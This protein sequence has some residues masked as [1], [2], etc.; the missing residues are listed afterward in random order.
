MIVKTFVLRDSAVFGRF[1]QWIGTNWEGQAAI[2]KPM[3]VQVFP[4][5]APVSPAQRG[6]YH[7]AVLKQIEAGA[8]VNGKQF[9]AKV[10]H[11]HFKAMVLG[12]NE[13]T[14]RPISSESLGMAGYAEFTEKVMQHAADTLGVEFDFVLP[15]EPS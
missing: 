8:W 14:G 11:E 2:D 13:K 12:R 4:W 3:V 9:P 10:W 6:F 1:L 15:K 5:D 7:G